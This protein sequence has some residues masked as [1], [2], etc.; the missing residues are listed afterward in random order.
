MAMAFHFVAD[1]I[2]RGCFRA[3]HVP[4]DIPDVYQSLQCRTIYYRYEVSSLSFIL[5]I[6]HFN[7]G[8]NQ[9]GNSRNTK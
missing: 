9:Y 4:D 1:D 6:H 8:K 5:S 3:G 2:T 7:K